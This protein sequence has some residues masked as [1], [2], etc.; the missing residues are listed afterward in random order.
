MGESNNSIKEF[1][2]FLKPRPLYL[3]V[4]MAFKKDQNIT[5][6]YISEILQRSLPTVNTPLRDMEKKGILV[7]EKKGRTRF[8]RP[9]N[10]DI[11]R[12]ILSSEEL[13]EYQR[14]LLP[15]L[16]H[17]SF[18]IRRNFE[19]QLYQLLKESYQIDREYA[20]K[21]PIGIVRPDILI[22][23][24]SKRIAI[25]VKDMSRSMS[26]SVVPSFRVS[27]ILGFITLLTKLEK[28]NEIILVLLLPKREMRFDSW[29]LIELIESMSTEK[30][31]I[32]VIYD[33]ISSSDLANELFT[34]SLAN[35]IKEKIG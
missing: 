25:E 13:I 24:G 22:T 17:G 16:M 18:F 4:L 9:N 28:L 12:K 15:K 35:R 3:E 6:S 30:V 2:E 5:P 29:K 1:V 11:F 33:N 27:E 34:K 26:G 31:K 7:S 14:K 10:K 8:Y 21:S 32:S 19:E 23:K 20:I